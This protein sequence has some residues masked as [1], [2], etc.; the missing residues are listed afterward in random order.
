LQQLNDL[1]VSPEALMAAC[2]GDT[3]VRKAYFSLERDYYLRI[4]VPDK[5]DNPFHSPED[6]DFVDCGLFDVTCS[7]LLAERIAAAVRATG[8][9][10]LDLIPAKTFFDHSYGG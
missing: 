2:T 7:H 8:V 3:Y 1:L 10:D 5:Y 6:P 4:Y 9:K